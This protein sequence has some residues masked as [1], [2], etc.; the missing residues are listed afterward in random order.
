MRTVSSIFRSTCLEIL[1]SLSIGANSGGTH[2]VR[3]VRA[4]LDYEP[5]GFYDEL[6]CYLSFVLNLTC[7][8]MNGM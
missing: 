5:R 2:F 6:V 1:R 3:C 4:D 7:N 8:V